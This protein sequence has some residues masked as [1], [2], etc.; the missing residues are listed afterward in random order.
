[1]RIL[2]KRVSKVGRNFCREQFVGDCVSIYQGYI[3]FFLEGV[4]F[5][6]RKKKPCKQKFSKFDCILIVNK[7]CR[8]VA[9]R[10]TFQIS[11]CETSVNYVFQI[12]FTLI[13]FAINASE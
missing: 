6:E 5:F 4:K 10:R 12:Y 2:L 3:Y 9:Q 1:M 8:K 7:G 13:Q 11:K